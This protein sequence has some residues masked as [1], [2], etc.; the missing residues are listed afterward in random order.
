MF[1]NNA[2]RKIFG[3]DQDE[4]IGKSSFGFVH[5]EDLHLVEGKLA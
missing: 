1:T 5:S 2:F 4:L 3:Y